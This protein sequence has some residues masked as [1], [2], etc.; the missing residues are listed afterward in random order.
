MTRLTFDG[1]C[2]NPL[3]SPDGR[4]IV[5]RA[6]REIRW[7]RVNGPGAAQVLA[8]GDSMLV[9]SSFS[10]DGKR[11]AFT[12][13][14]SRSGADIWT[15][16]IES[17]GESLRPGKPAMFL[18]TNFNER[19]PA[20]SPD[21]RRIAYSSDE[22]GILEV[23]VRNYPD[24]GGKVQISN[25]GG[26]FP[27]W[28][29]KTSELFLTNGDRNNQLM[30]VKYA[31]Q[32]VALRPEKARRW[33]DNVLLFTPPSRNYDLALDGRHAIAILSAPGEEKEAAER[34]VVLLQHFFDELQRRVPRP[35]T[36]ADSSQDTRAQA[37]RYR[38]LVQR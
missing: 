4:F 9:P 25:G 12:E 34:H 23:Y 35:A 10:P 37:G 19:T 28:S 32:G 16:P 30:T 26:N 20:F 21:G 22:T 29:P 24:Q 15:L 31:I 8:S 17:D 13:V 7:I 36:R 27:V 33:S 6:P 18:G 5:F 1:G 2:N 11:L 14:N 38:F 3:W